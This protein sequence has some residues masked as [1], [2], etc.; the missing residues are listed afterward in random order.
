MV[1]SISSSAAVDVHSEVQPSPMRQPA[2]T[3]KPELS[4][5]P[6]AQPVAADTVRISPAA[7]SLHKRSK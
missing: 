7:K 5:A 2:P 4:S 1:T 3:S 6:K